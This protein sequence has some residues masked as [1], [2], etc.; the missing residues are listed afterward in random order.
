MCG[1]LYKNSYPHQIQHQMYPTDFQWYSQYLFRDFDLQKFV[2]K[3]LEHVEDFL[4][5]ELMSDWSIRLIL[6]HF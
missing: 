2:L 5:L 4:V 1:H 3:V 6:I